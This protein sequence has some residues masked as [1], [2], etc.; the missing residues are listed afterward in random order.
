MNFDKI[1][2]NNS[3]GQ[4]ITTINKNQSGVYNLQD[5]QNGLYY[6]TFYNTNNEKIGVSKLIKQD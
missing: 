4:I 2:I 5:I 6:I 3:L 1:S